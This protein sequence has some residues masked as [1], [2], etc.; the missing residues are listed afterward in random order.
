MKYTGILVTSMTAVLAVALIGCKSNPSKEQAASSAEPAASTSAATAA[1][2]ADAQQ[3][4]F[5][6]DYTRLEED[7]GDPNRLSWVN[8]EMTQDGYSGVIVAPVVFHL[9]PELAKDGVRPDATTLNQIFDYFHKALEREFGNYFEV[10]DTP[11]DG[12]MRYQ[13]AI[14]GLDTESDTSAVHFLPVV[15]V[16]RT[17]SGGGKVEARIFMEAYAKDSLTGELLAEVVQSGEGSEVED[18]AEV[19]LSNVRP[20]LDAW[21]KKAAV[22][23]REATG[24]AGM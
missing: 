9:D 17:A 22:A 6:P 12:V 20:V 7:A 5:L 3:E 2:P 23:A 24:K 4:R 11:G 19:T 14:T 15:F 18:D 13:A 10:T 21:A 8:E 16:A 1:K